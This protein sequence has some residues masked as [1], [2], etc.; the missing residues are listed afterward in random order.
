MPS[1]SPL[2][3]FREALLA[4]LRHSGSAPWAR[5]SFRARPSYK[6]SYLVAFFSLFARRN[7]SREEVKREMKKEREAGSTAHTTHCVCVE[8]WCSS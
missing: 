1:M 8:L 7:A 4:F 2:T 6:A 5:Y 3:A